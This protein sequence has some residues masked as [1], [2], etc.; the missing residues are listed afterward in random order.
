MYISLGMNL[1]RLPRATPPPAMAASRS[2]NGTTMPPAAAGS[3]TSYTVSEQLAIATSPFSYAGIEAELAPTFADN[4]APGTRTY[5]A[6]AQLLFGIHFGGRALNFA[7]ELAGGG[8]FVDTAFVNTAGEE[9]TLEARARG[10]LWLTPW[11]TFGA[12]LGT[13]LLDRDEWVTGIHLA[14]HSYS[15]G[16]M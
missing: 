5:V 16:G 6:G 12:T 1:R 3:D 13:S 15:Y 9:W 2:T 8:R 11:V 7:G 14:V 4:V 10:D